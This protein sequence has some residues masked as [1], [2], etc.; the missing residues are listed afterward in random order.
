MT[1]GECQGISRGVR[2]TAE[3]RSMLG[4][5]SASRIINLFSLTFLPSS[6]IVAKMKGCHSDRN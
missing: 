1:S 3:Y 4:T 6:L 5:V 2:E